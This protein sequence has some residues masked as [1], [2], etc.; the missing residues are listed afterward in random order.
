MNVEGCFLF[1]CFYFRYALRL[2]LGFFKFVLNL[3]KTTF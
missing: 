1:V 2:F 3:K